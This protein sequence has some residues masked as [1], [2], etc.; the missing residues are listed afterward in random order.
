MVATMRTSRTEFGACVIAGDIYV[1]GGM[2]VDVS[3]LSSVEKYSPAVDTWNA[4]A[5]MP[6]ARQG[7]VSVAV[8]SDLFVL[9]GIDYAGLTCLTL[10]FDSILGAWSE[11]AATPIGQVRTAAAVGTDIYAFC[12][13]PN[14]EL[15]DAVHKYD[16]LI[17]QWS[18]LAPMPFFD[19][20][21][22]SAN[23]IDGLIYI[24]GFGETLRFDP[25]LG[26]WDTLSL[27]LYPRFCCATFVLGRSLY[28]AGGAGDASN[29][30]RYDVSTDTWTMVADMLQP[31]RSFSAVTTYVEG[32]AIEQD[33]FDSLITKASTGRP[34]IA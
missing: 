17:D 26:L 1:T 9:G 32:P 19:D 15:D 24:V 25:A 5:P 11:A 3:V 34:L 12:Q 7:H 21:D 13:G 33:L 23:V 4:V 28:A 20:N 8:G 30:E 31:R 22:I 18:N 16:T 10:K 29:V 2:D 6:E 14:G 27:T